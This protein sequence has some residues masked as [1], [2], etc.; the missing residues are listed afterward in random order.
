V[1]TF[2]AV[3]SRREVREYSDA[4]LPADIVRRILDA[5]RLSGSSRNT[6]K[7]TFV[8]VS[9]REGMSE[10]VFAP[11]NV[12]GAALVVAIVGDVAPFDVGRAAQNMLLTAWNEGV[13]SCPNGVRDAEA[14]ERIA[15]GSV[16]IVLTFGYPA[17][18]RRDPGSRTAEEWSARASRKPFDE[19]VRES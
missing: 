18:P 13:G 7:W 1:D 4:P 2:L 11:A 12:R 5:G 3:A 17:A 15:G 14:A 8:V 10:A 6:Q 19:V 9:D 16:R